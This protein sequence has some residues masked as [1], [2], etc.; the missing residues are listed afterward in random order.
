M[1]DITTIEQ[2]TYFAKKVIEADRKVLALS[3]GSSRRELRSARID[4]KNLEKRLE[5]FTRKHGLAICINYK[6]C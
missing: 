5:D 6:A 1:N 2:L 4:R 3:H